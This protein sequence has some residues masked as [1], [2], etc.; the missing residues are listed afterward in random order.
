MK[1]VV[2]DN[3]E[4][5]SAEAAKLVEEKVRENQEAVLGLATGSTPIGLYKNLIEGNKTRG[6]SY[7][8][9]KAVNLDEYLGLSQDHSQSYHT[10]MK[11]NLFSQIDIKPENTYIPNGIPASAEEECTGYEAVITKVGPVNLQILGIGTNGH[12]GF[13]EPGTPGDS[14]THVVELT[15]STRESNGPN[16]ETEAEVPT[17]AISMGIQTILKGEEIILLASGE[18]KAEA[19]KMLLTKKVTEDNPA[20]FLWTHDNV[21]LIVDK[22]A[23]QLVK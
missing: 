12:I 20:S 21:T 22:D 14:I 5:M 6:I 3:Y 17:H 2:V 19:I 4:A 10:F 11:E 18:S 23:Y 8:D 7:K 15:K 9:V 13:N 1:V 16:F